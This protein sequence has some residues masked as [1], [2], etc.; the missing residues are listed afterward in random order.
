[1]AALVPLRQR[2][3]LNLFRRGQMIPKGNPPATGLAWPD[4][5]Q[6]AF[7]VHSNSRSDP[8]VVVIVDAVEPVAGQKFFIFAFSS[9]VPTVTLVGDGTS[10]QVD[11]V[12]SGPRTTLF[13]FDDYED[14]DLIFTIDYP[15]LPNYAAHRGWRTVN[16]AYVPGSLRQ[17]LGLTTDTNPGVISGV[18]IPPRGFL[19]L[20]SHKYETL[21][22]TPSAGITITLEPGFVDAW[23]ATSEEGW[24]GTLTFSTVVSANNKAGFCAS[25]SE[26]TA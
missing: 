23:T 3:P 6:L 4:S 19:L 25:F 15:G 9:N 20:G 11:Q 22:A 26:V 21:T 12:G 1:M 7:P 16:A 2:P 8:Y 10:T 17:G 14:A 5:F 24:T 18:T 13:R